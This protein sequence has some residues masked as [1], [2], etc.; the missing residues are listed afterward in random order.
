M[1][2]GIELIA[3]ISRMEYTQIMKRSLLLL[4]ALMLLGGCSGKSVEKADPA[5]LYK[6]AEEDIDSDHYQVAIEKLRAIKNK[7]PYSKYALDAQL[8]IADVLYL[9]E[10]YTEA[11]SAYES[12]ADLHPKHERVA[13]A[14]YRAAKSYYNDIPSPLSRDLTPAQRA[15]E[16]YE[17]FIRRFPNAPETP[18]ARKDMAETRRV[19]AEKELYIGD[20]YF[21]RDF[22]VS[23]KP[24]YEKLIALFPETE[25]A[26]KAKEKIVKIDQIFKEH[27]EKMTEGKEP[28][29]K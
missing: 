23:A 2:Q 21:K 15:E 13:Y 17:S 26:K 22:Y 27:P 1:D 28:S 25:A 14:M 10:M 20:F 7:F 12:F 9:Q 16:S 29:K 18:E 4:M 3:L 6:D 11:A 24:R 5:L 8:R 19:L